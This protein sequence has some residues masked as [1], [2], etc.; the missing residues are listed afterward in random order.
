MPFVLGIESS[1]DETAAA[2]VD[3]HRRVRSNIVASQHDLHAR[4]AGVVPELASRAHL[5]RLVPV[6]REACSRAGVRLQDID[7]VAVGHAPGLIGSL[8]VGVSAAKAIAWS[9][10]V[11]LLGVHHIMAHLHAAT[12]DEEALDLPAVG[13]V[14]SG[15]HTHVYELDASGRTRTL[16]WTIDD[17]IGEAFD[18]AGAM[19]RAGYPG[20]PA[21]EAL[22]REGNDAAVD[23]PIGRPR[24]GGFSFSGLKT[25]LL[26]ALRGQ[27]RRVD[28]QTVFPRELDDVDDAVRRDM[29]A[30]FQ[31]AAIAGLRQG[32]EAALDQAGALRCLLAGGGVIANAS[33]RRML[34]EVALQRGVPLRIP[35]VELCMDNAAM[36][37]GA[38][39]ADLE[40][41]RSCDLTLQAAAREAVA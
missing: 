25:A 15:G 16:A 5:E 13:L 8:L 7:A 33:V 10:G 9:L 4:F 37:A 38:G 26:Y 6:I 28:G 36:I 17:A 21:V 31:R 14:A 41:G 32:L 18:K 39:V 19:L 35:P 12:L 40:A 20:G 34:E 11:P 24:E 29:A 27:P 22:A 23:L 1:C 30:S 3:E 2:I